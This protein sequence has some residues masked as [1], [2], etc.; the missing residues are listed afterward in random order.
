MTAATAVA[1]G[2]AY[3]DRVRPAWRSE[4]DVERLDISDGGD[5]VIGQLY[6]SFDLGIHRVMPFL[7]CLF[8]R[9]WSKRHGFYPDYRN[10][11]LCSDL[12]AGWLRVIG[13][14]HASV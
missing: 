10:G 6:G 7:Q 2:A 13:G 14:D 8:W 9:G 1:R 4:I 3:L 11:I 5:C 12:N